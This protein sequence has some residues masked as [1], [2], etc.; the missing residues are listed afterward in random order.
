MIDGSKCILTVTPC[1]I[2]V[3]L[4]YY[5]EVTTLYLQ[6]INLGLLSKSVTTH[7]QYPL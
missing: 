1:G 6:G 4:Q 5:C 7:A 2:V 3:H